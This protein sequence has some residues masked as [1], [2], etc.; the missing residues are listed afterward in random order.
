MVSF[1]EGNVVN[2]YKKTAPTTKLNEYWEQF[3]KTN[4]YIL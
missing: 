4:D 1:I 2:K 3:R